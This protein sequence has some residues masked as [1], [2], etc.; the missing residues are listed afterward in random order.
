M[1]DRAELPPYVRTVTCAEDTYRPD[2]REDEYF[3]KFNA[4]GTYDQV[5]TPFC[6]DGRY[7]WVSVSSRSGEAA[8]SLYERILSGQ[9]R[10]VMVI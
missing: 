3:H 9:S 1:P 6:E 10:A 5:L 2:F 8:T 7:L 4:D